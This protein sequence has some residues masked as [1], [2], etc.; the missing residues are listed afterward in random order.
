M[1]MRGAMLL[2][3]SSTV[4]VGRRWASSQRQRTFAGLKWAPLP[5]GVGLAY[6]CYQQYHHIREKNRAVG[7]IDMPWPQWK[8]RHYRII[9]LL[10]HKYLQ[11]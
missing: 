1:A 8:V 9:L 5:V 4:L 11:K 2:R 10:L 3:Q 7:D 6:I